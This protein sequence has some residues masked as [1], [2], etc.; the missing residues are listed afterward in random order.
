MVDFKPNILLLFF[1]ILPNICRKLRKTRAKVVC[2]LVGSR[3]ALIED[4]ADSLVFILFPRDSNPNKRGKQHL[5][6]CVRKEV[7]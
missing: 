2:P 1:N 6:V 4:P 5:C 7:T 3:G